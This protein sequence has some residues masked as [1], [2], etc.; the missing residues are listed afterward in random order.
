MK[1]TIEKMDTKISFEND[2]KKDVLLTGYSFIDEM[3]HC[4]IIV[5]G[6]R[7]RD[8]IVEYLSKNEKG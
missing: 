6:E 8:L 3:G 7:K 1:H 2:K 4:F 5:Y